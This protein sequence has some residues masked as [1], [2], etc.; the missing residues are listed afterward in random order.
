MK[1]LN[2]LLH[3]YSFRNSDYKVRDAQSRETPW[4]C[5]ATI[6]H[7]V[8]M[9]SQTMRSTCFPKPEL[10]FQKIPSFPSADFGLELDTVIEMGIKNLYL[11]SDEYRSSKWSDFNLLSLFPKIFVYLQEPAFDRLFFSKIVTRDASAE[12]GSAEQCI[13]NIRK[14]WQ[15]LFEKGKT[16]H[17]RESIRKAG[18]V[19]KAAD[20]DNEDD[21]LSYAQWLQAAFDFLAMVTLSWNI[22]SHPKSLSRARSL[23]TI[24]HRN[25]LMFYL[26]QAYIDF[27]GLDHGFSQKKNWASGKA[28]HRLARSIL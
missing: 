9:H 8:C 23:L 14:S 4:K 27:F 11:M 20:L 1:F 3:S 12:A 25:I 13:P 16:K 28:R 18:Q 22:K 15:V 5:P 26:L 19:C 21:V 10:H 24:D 17:G 6:S 2:T 7:Y